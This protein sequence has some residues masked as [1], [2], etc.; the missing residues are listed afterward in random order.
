MKWRGRG[1]AKQ[2]AGRKQTH[3]LCLHAV[4]KY[5]KVENINSQNDYETKTE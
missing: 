4:G 5:G 1:I 2:G 3:P